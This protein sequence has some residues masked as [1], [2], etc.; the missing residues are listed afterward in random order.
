MKEETKDTVASSSSFSP[1]KEEQPQEENEEQT[2][3]KSTTTLATTTIHVL[4]CS[5]VPAAEPLVHSSSSSSSVSLSSPYKDEDE[6]K[7]ED[8]NDGYGYDDDGYEEYVLTNYS[9]DFMSEARRD[10]NQ[11]WTMFDEGDDDDEECALTNY[12]SFDF[13][14]EVRRDYHRLSTVF[15]CTGSLLVSTKIW[16]KQVTPVYNNA[17]SFTTGAKVNDKLET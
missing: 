5:A 16:I 1:I 3:A 9:S 10:Y 13:M 2:E 15:D 11:L 12:N 14:S 6:D 8:D 7:D 17:V 4:D